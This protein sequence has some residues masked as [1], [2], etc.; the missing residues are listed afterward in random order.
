MRIPFLLLTLGGVAIAQSPSSFP[1]EVAPLAMPVDASSD[2]S[3]TAIDLATAALPPRQPRVCFDQPAADGPM[4]ASATAWKASFDGTGCTVI[5]FFGSEAPHNFPLRL[6]LAQVAVGGES[7]ELPAGEPERLG[8]RVRTRRGIVDE[9][10]DTAVD[11]LEQSWVFASLPNR[12]AITVDLSMQGD[13]QVTPIDGGLRFGT[14]LGHFDYHSA[15]AVD[16]D[17]KRLPLSIEWD[18][19]S[20]QLTVPASRRS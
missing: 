1:R 6:E 17:G 5:P 19:D 16:A 10:I 18:G 3:V 14:N 2:S 11:G 20:A 15:V 13:Y 8:Q 4:W 12:G 7:L 9:V